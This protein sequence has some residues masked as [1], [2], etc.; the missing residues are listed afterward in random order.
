MKS[1][2]PPHD[3][4]YWRFRFPPAQPARYRWAI[5]QGDWK[6]VKNDPEPVSLYHLATDIGETKN[7][8]AE[9]PDRVAAMQDAW[10]RWDAENKE[11]LDGWTAA[12]AGALLRPHP[13]A[14]HAKV[15]SFPPRSAWNAPATTRSSSSATSRAATG[16]FTLELKIKST[17]KGPGEVFWSTAAKPQVRR[18]AERQVRTPA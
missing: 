18:R 7:L 5:R 8:A 17:S 10:N 1:R 11:P 6:L 3:T 16:P 13:G 15:K 12:K 2:V 9:Q 14:Y 4:L